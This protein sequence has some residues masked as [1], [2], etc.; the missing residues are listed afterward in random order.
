MR[1]RTVALETERVVPIAVAFRA[2]RQENWIGRNTAA[3][4][5]PAGALVAYICR[6]CGFTEF[7]TSGAADLPIG[8]PHGTRLLEYGSD[9]PYR[10]ISPRSRP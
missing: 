8:E 6:A 5:S 3:V 2:E 9:G 10:G 4:G 1:E 7:Y